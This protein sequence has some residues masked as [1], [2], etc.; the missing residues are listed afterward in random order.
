MFWK[1][2]E[3]FLLWPAPQ[4]SYFLFFISRVIVAC[5]PTI[6]LYL[7]AI[8]W[9]L[10]TGIAFLREQSSVSDHV[11]WLGT[12][13]TSLIIT[14]LFPAEIPSGGDWLLGS[15]FVPWS[16]LVYSVTRENRLPLLLRQFLVHGHG[17]LK[18]RGCRIKNSESRPVRNNVLSMGDEFVH[19]WLNCLTNGFTIEGQGLSIETINCTK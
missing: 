14:I 2:I 16:D 15:Q 6:Q 5:R 1:R 12:I 3:P 17:Y 9:L 11:L 19:F 7:F 10:L 8:I 4:S 18:L 13:I